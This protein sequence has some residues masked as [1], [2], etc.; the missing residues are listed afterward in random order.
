MTRSN[1]IATAGIA[2]ACAL[3]LAACGNSESDAN[4]NADPGNDNQYLRPNSVLLESESRT[5]TRGDPRA[6]WDIHRFNAV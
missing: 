1:R 6:H 5:G 3:A 4:P 2:V